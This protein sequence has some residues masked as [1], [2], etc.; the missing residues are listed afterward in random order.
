MFL[1]GAKHGIHECRLPASVAKSGLSHCCCSVF[2]HL[3]HCQVLTIPKPHDTWGT[4]VEQ[5]RW[6]VRQL[7]ALSEE[8]FG[9]GRVLVCVVVG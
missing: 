7:C 8:S 4:L 9:V 2:L 6:V 1:R 3:L 5:L